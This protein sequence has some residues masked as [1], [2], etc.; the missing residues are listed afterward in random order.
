MANYGVVV[1]NKVA[2]TDIGTLNRSALV[3]SQDIENGMVMQLASRSSTTGE[4][5]V[6]VGTVP[7]SSAGLTHLW[8][9]YSPELSRVVSGSSTYLGLNPDPRQHF[10]AQGKVFDV[11]KPQVGD[12]ITLT[13]DAITGDKSTN[14]HVVA[15]ASD[16]QLNWASAAVSGL[17]LKL[18][19]T[20]YIS[21]PDGGI[22]TGRVAAYRFEC[23]AIA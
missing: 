11:F 20:T 13:A 17:S 3:S 1:L 23:V 7:S 12:I 8:M 21:L 15:T 18:L 14:T 9:A 2:A 10:N 6:W 4:E 22:N 19:D 5:E 16:F